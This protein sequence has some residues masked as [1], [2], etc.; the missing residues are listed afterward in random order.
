MSLTMAV[1]SN[2]GKRETGT[3]TFIITLQIDLIFHP[4]NTDKGNS[5]KPPLRLW[6]K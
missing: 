4:I 6:L 5:R 1:S 3:T 2:L